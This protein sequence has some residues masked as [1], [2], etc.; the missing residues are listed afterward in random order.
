MRDAC[1]AFCVTRAGF[2]EWAARSL[3]ALRLLV[4]PHR[5]VPG[6]QDMAVHGGLGQGGV[7]VRDRGD[8]V[9]VLQDAAALSVARRGLPDASTMAA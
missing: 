1:I 8:D 6:G 9:P 7:T 4:Q 5:R 2:A 3:R